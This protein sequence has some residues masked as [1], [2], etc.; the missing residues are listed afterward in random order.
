MKDKELRK[1]L[2]GAGVIIKGLA[3][4]TFKF[5]KMVSG[6]NDKLGRI[7]YKLERIDRSQYIICTKWSFD[8]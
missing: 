7:D 6:Y 5:D 4:T 2:E 1:A 3:A 8:K